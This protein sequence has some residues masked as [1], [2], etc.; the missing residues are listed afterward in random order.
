MVV[1]I[2]YKL[3]PLLYKNQK[4]K[5]IRETRHCNFTIYRGDMFGCG[6]TMRAVPSDIFLNVHEI[7]WCQRNIPASVD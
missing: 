2:T 7:F 1:E 5:F 4:V 6:D 3:K